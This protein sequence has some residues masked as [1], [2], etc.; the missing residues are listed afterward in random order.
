MIKLLAIDLDGTLLDSKG[1]INKE[2]KIA[3]KRFYKKGGIV[4]LASGRMTDCVSI[5]SKILE[6]DTPLIVYNGAMVR[7]REKEKRKIVYHNPVPLKYSRFIIDYCFKK[8]FFLNFYYKDLLY[9][10]D[11]PKL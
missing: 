11:N 7:L 6:I 4:A 1:K 9:A 5:Y 10:T 8:D 2:D 3:L